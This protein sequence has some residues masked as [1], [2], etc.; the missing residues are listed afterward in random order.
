MGRRL[1]ITEYLELDLDQGRWF[2][3]SCDRDLIEAEENYKKGCRVYIRDPREIHNPVFEAEYNFA[4]DPNWSR[5]LE[6]YCPGLRG[7]DRNGI[8]SPGS[9][10]DPRHR[11]RRRRS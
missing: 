7:A 3:G 1:I 10:G 11:H 8:P 9:S 6:F 2:C 4:P 5:I